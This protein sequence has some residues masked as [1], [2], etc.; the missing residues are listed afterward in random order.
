MT[1]SSPRRSAAIQ[2][3]IFAGRVV[4]SRLAFA[5]PGP[6]RSSGILMSWLGVTGMA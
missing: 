4:R 5:L 2:L 1:C 3:L 6:H